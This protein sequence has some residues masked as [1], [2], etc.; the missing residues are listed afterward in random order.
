MLAYKISSTIFSRQIEEAK[1]NADHEVRAIK[2]EK[3]RLDGELKG[4]RR[5]KTSL[6]EQQAEG[7]KI[8][9]RLAAENEELKTKLK[10]AETKVAT[11]AEKVDT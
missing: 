1:E 5:E 4:L 11:Q 6:A 9:E 8:Q 10:E 3:E 2:A 7:K